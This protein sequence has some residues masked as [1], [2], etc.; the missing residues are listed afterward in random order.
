[1]LTTHNAKFGLFHNPH[2]KTMSYP[3]V[4]LLS[5]GSTFLPLLTGAVLLRTAS[6]RDRSLG[7][8][9]LFFTLAAAT[10]IIALTLNFH[11][12]PSAWISHA[13][14]L[15]EY[16]LITHILIYWQT[17]SNLIR[18][19]H[20]SISAYLLIFV[21]TKASGLENFSAETINYITRP[22]AIIFLAA[23]SF[24]TLQ[25]LSHQTL[26]SLIGNYR[27]W[28]LLAMSLYYSASLVIFAFLF[29]KNQNLL[30]T[31]FKI[32]AVFNIIHN[33]LFTIGVL[34]V[35]RARQTTLP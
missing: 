22:L 12:L 9:L 1:M 35:Y 27:Y 21:L 10:E 17:N 7:F 13:Y 15:I 29:I 32:H 20:F 3:P 24:L 33:I 16:V 25:N 14:T 8:L 5:I 2:A 6:K 28:I 4:I 11:K 23:F 18:F 30:I 26:K 34:Q 19:M 31:L